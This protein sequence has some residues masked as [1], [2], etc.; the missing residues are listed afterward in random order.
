M[1]GYD[2]AALA[3][4]SGKSLSHIYA[5]L[6]LLQLIPAVAEAFVADRITA[7]HA[8]LI[9]RLPQEHQAAALENC[10]RKDWQDAEPH[11]LP[12]KHLGSWIETN[13]F[14]DLAEAP[15]DRE[16]V[17]LI[18]EAGGCVSCPKRS[19]YN[20]S[21]FPDVAGDQC[22]DGACYQSKVTAHIDRAL[23]NNPQLVQIETSWRPAKEQRPGVLAKQQYQVLDIS[24]NPDADPPCAY[25]KNALI[26]FGREAGRTVSI[27]TDK[28]CPVHDPKTAA[29]IAREEAENPAPIIEPPTEEETEEEAQ[30]REAENQRRREEYQAEEDRKAAERKAKAERQQREYEAET[31]RR[32]AEH[33]ARLATLERIVDHAPAIFDAVQLRL[34]VELLL[35]LPPYGVFEEVAEHF[36]GDDENHG[37]TDN[38]ILLEALAACAD[39]KLVGFILRLLLTVHVD[40]PRGEQTDWLLKVESLLV[41]NSKARKKAAGKQQPTKVKPKTGTNTTRKKAA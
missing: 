13:L 17:A 30:E 37:K 41:P 14:L 8:N 7:S 31:Q 20:T 11:L 22:L 29:R 38:E 35:D 15:F 34:F 36:A 33:N 1:P 23:A 39:D 2:V 24:D 12:A 40:V 3:A 18:S 28:E 26:V 16:D 5:R 21:L 27:C 4:K 25:T 32:I 6:S 10:W 9:A 19:A